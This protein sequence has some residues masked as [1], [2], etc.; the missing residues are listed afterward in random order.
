MPRPEDHLST[1]FLIQV[2]WGDMD[3]DDKDIYEG[4]RVRD[5][6]LKLALIPESTAANVVVLTDAFKGEEG[7]FSHFFLKVGQL[8][9]SVWI[10]QECSG[11]LDDFF[12][13]L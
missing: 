3:H 9:G 10:L 12:L 4:L 2:S 5:V 1:H 7:F 13:R 6:I 8:F 11:H